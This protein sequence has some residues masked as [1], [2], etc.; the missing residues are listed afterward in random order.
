MMREPSLF[1]Y[2]RRTSMQHRTGRVLSVA[3]LATTAVTVMGATAASAAPAASSAG[4]TGG[5][6]TRMA[7]AYGGYPLHVKTLT[8]KVVAPLQLSVSKKYGVLVGDSGASKLLQIVRGGN[9]RTVASGPQPG[10]VSGNDVNR[11]G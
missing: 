10:E 8:T 3:A 1:P 5:T 7:A 6:S 9:V 2:V 4:G 11:Y